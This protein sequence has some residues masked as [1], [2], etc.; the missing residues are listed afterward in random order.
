[1]IDAIRKKHP[2]SVVRMG[3][4]E[5]GLMKFFVENAKPAFLQKWWFDRIHMINVSD[6][7]I[8]AIGEK[9]IYTA[10]HA[11]FLASSIWGSS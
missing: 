7:H 1:M 4:G 8:K 2:F 6:E 3:D 5:A 10:N 11:D 9:L